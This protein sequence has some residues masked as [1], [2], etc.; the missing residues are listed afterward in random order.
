MQRPRIRITI[1]GMVILVAVVALTA[2]A[3]ACSPWAAK[4]RDDWEQAALHAEWEQTCRLMAR[5]DREAM[6]IAA[7]TKMGVSRASA[8]QIEYNEKSA[9]YHAAFKW[10][11]RRSALQPWRDVQVPSDMPPMPDLPVPTPDSIA[12]PTPDHVGS[13]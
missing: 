3:G 9:A 13:P 7:S 2:A 11:Y 12:L 5:M 1:R 10:H 8:E 4:C 6:A